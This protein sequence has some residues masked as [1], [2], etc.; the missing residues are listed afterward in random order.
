MLAKL[1]FQIQNI[2]LMALFKVILE[3]CLFERERERERMLL[4]AFDGVDRSLV[5]LFAE[6]YDRTV[7]FCLSRSATQ[8]VWVY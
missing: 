6:G 4:R 7:T 1:T 2:N 3:Y 5:K 8:T